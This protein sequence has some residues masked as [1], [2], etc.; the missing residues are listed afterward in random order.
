MT[1]QEFL[2]W[3]KGYSAAVQGCDFGPIVAIFKNEDG[4]ILRE[5]TLEGFTNLPASC[6]KKL[7][8]TK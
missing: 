8:E 6:K 1:D 3:I 4:S 7:L 5:R 2:A